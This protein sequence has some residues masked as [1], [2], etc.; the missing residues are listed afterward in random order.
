MQTRRFSGIAPVFCCLLMLPTAMSASGRDVDG[1]LLSLMRG[2]GA[3]GEIFVD[4][5]RG[6]GHVRLVPSSSLLAD[7][8]DIPIPDDGVL[9][10]YDA[11]DAREPVATSTAPEGAESLVIL[12]LPDGDPDDEVPFR[13]AALD[14]SADELKR[15]GIVFHNAGPFE[16]RIKVGDDTHDVAAEASVVIPNPDEMEGHR[17]TSL[18]IEVLLDER[19]RRLKETSER[20]V[21]GMVV[22]M[23]AYEPKKGG[24]PRLGVFKQR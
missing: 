21:E 15:G 9:R 5:G 20:M 12:L 14:S 13:C 3:P 8:V 17:M 22:W 7:P 1:R 19:W 6:K 11:R 16:A 24:R 2:A 18:V 23:V 10:F 4:G